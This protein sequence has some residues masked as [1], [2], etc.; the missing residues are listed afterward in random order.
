[1]ARDDALRF[2]ITVEDPDLQGQGKRAAREA[3][4]EAE[5]AC[6]FDHVDAEA[7][8]GSDLRVKS[9]ASGKWLC[10]N[11]DFVYRHR[12]VKP[13]VSTARLAQVLASMTERVDDFADK[14]GYDTD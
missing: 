14:A 10:F 9:Y 13:S 12:P 8:L 1:V 11:P 6:F 7:I 2:W 5:H 4:V 3:I